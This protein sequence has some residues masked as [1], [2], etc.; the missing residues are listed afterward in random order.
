MKTM[1][2]CDGEGPHSVPVRKLPISD[3]PDHGNAI[4]C[5][6]CFEKEMDFRKERNKELEPA[7]QFTLLNWNA[8]EIYP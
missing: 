6:L 4:L 1:F 3:N 7:A 5:R 2:A 8:L